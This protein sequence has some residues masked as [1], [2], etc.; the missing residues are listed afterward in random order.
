MVCASGDEELVDVDVQGE[1]GHHSMQL[2][3]VAKSDMG[4]QAVL[5]LEEKILDWS[6]NDMG[7]S[8][9]V[10][11]LKR[12]ENPRL[13]LVNSV[14]CSGSNVS[15]M[16]QAILE[17]LNETWNFMKDDIEHHQRQLLNNPG[18]FLLS[19]AVI[20]TLQCLI[21]NELHEA[22]GFGTVADPVADE[23]LDVVVLAV[24]E[25]EVASGRAELVEAIDD[26][27]MSIFIKELQMS[28]G[29]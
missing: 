3:K 9:I 2:M 13:A 15:K 23:A 25:S 29:F 8:K 19:N 27:Q 22:T 14:F 11:G 4:D 24:S 17:V 18:Q 12:G 10:V 26:L 20:T 6:R 21:S 5:E 1:Y 7:D 16:V 28:R